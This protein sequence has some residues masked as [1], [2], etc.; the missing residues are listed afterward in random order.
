MRSV[1]RC[2]GHVGVFDE[3]L[4][5]LIEEGNQL[6][7]V[8]HLLLGQRVFHILVLILAKRGRDYVWGMRHVLL[9]L[10]RREEPP[11][12]DAHGE[13]IRGLIIIFELRDEGTELLRVPVDVLESVE[14][15]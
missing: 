8:T 1:C 2:L 15:H 13:L 6:I 10:V 9:L 7:I 11:A 12:Q 4:A 14:T 5:L 3:L